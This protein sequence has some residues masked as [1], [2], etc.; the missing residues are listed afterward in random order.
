MARSF[1]LPPFD[2]QSDWKSETRLY[3]NSAESG[4]RP[5]LERR[6]W[7]ARRPTGSARASQAPPRRSSTENR[8]NRMLSREWRR[9]ENGCAP[10]RARADARAEGIPVRRLRQ[11]RLPLCLPA[12]IAA[13][14]KR[15]RDT[16]KPRRRRRSASRS[17]T[18]PPGPGTASHRNLRERFP[19]WKRASSA[20]RKGESVNDEMAMPAA[21]ATHTVYIGPGESRRCGSAGRSSD[22]R[23]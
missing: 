7:S 11:A 8:T 5:N 2:F 20:Y 1:N 6:A 19:R 3:G 16:R 10:I 9:Q 14:A 15:R 18:P 21:S 4:G 12:A 17:P 13:E 22:E 23:S